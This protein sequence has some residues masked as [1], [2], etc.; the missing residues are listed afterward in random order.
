MKNR[1]FFISFLITLFSLLTLKSQNLIKYNILM[2]KNHFIYLIKTNTY[3][4]FKEECLAINYTNFL[5]DFSQ[6][7]EEVKIAT[8]EKSEIKEVNNYSFPTF[9]YNINLKI[10]FECGFF[11][12]KY[13]YKVQVGEN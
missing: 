6:K 13:V 9:A 10:K 2:L 7:I 8:I 11:I 5:K 1:L 4:L 12:E 3:Y